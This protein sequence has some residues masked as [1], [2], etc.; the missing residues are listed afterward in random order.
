MKKII[1]I[2]IAL[3][4]LNSIPIK[5]E[6]INSDQRM[7]RLIGEIHSELTTIKKEHAWLMKYNEH[8]LDTKSKKSLIFYMPVKRG[9]TRKHT[10]PQ[11]LDQLSISY[12]PIN[13]EKKGKYD[14]DVEKI[15]ECWFPELGFKIYAHILIRKNGEL[16]KS[17][18][19]I[20]T[21]KCSELHKNLKKGTMRQRHS[22]KKIAGNFSRIGFHFF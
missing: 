3:F 10:Q 5:A 21:E 14:N 19:N 6:E 22:V 17:I 7:N 12:V 18:E 11:M 13:A 8:C 1:V 9:S 20:V 2:A 16:K 15:K 4:F